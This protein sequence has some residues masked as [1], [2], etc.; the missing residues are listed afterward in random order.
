MDK[1]EEN[2]YD[3][4]LSLWNRIISGDDNAYQHIYKMYAKGLFLQGLQFVKDKELVRDCIH[5]VFVKIYANKTNLNPVSNIRLYLFVS[6][7][8][9]II[10]ICKSRNT[11][12]EELHE[13]SEDVSELRTVEDDYIEEETAN[14]SKELVTRI[15][16]QLSPRQREAIHYRFIQGLSIEEI[17]V[18]MGMNYQSVQNILQRSLNKM[19]YFLKKKIKK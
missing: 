3:D 14:Q 13:E 19:K 1:I 2:K 4:D 12:F 15:F 16:N 9:T 6:L 11:F 17:G 10:T 5:D 7:K 8:N 18:L